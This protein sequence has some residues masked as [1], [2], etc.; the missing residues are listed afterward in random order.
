MV[1]LFIAVAVVLTLVAMSIRANKRLKPAERL[2]MQWSF[3]GEVN[4]TAP[5]RFALAFTPAL[6]ALSLCLVVTLV[7][8]S[9]EQRQGQEGLAVA[10]VL[11]VGAIFI[12]IHAMHLRLMARSLG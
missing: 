5:R 6:A 8:F 2:P 3:A 9:K 1:E 4:G 12:G 7:F 10:V 11:F